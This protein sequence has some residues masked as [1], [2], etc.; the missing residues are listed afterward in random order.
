MAHRGAI[1]K[2]TVAVAQVVEAEAA[3]TSTAEGASATPE[4][5]TCQVAR[6]QAHQSTQPAPDN[7]NLLSEMKNM[8][9]SL[10]AAAQKPAQ[11]SSTQLNPE[12]QRRP[13]QYGQG[14]NH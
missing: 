1:N 14:Y 7:Q 11:E 12:Q 9:A 4:P 10:V 6:A 8:L 13:Q 3:P 2:S 5:G